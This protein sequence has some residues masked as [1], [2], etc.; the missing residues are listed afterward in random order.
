[1]GVGMAHVSGARRM[2]V[3][4]GGIP[5]DMNSPTSS[6]RQLLPDAEEFEGFLLELGKPCHWSAYSLTNR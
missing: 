4:G 1:M 3:N 2:L 5:S 6:S